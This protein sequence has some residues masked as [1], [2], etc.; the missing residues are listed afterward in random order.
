MKKLVAVACAIG[1][2]AFS[3]PAFALFTNGGFEVGDF[4][5]WTITYGNVYGAYGSGDTSTPAWTGQFNAYGYTPHPAPQI[6]TAAT[7]LPGQTLD[8]NPYNGNN[9]AMINDITGYWHATRLSQTDTISAADI[10]DTLYVNWGA[11]LVDPS[12]DAYAQPFFSIQVLRNGSLVQSFAANATNASTPGSGWVVAGS[13][14]Y[15]PLYYKAEQY[16]YT[17][18]SGIFN[19]GDNI[20]IEMFVTDC[21]W[22]GHGGYA[23]LDGIGTDYVPPP[24]G[25]PVPEPSTIALLGLGLAGV[26]VMRKKMRK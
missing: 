17:L 6:I 5:G 10:G 12:H 11:M 21:G 23:F 19:V 16:T 13:D 3:A 15:N 4:S 20:T 14:G 7:T 26:V 24:D 25:N 9:M 2:F 18:G 22:G 8:V 1:M